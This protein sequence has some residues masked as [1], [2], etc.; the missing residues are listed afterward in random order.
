MDIET[1]PRR[2]TKVQRTTKKRRPWEGRLTAPD[3]PRPHEPIARRARWRHPKSN[4]PVA[5]TR[6]G[7][8]EAGLRQSTDHGH[9]EALDVG[10]RRTP[11][12]IST[13][14]TKRAWVARR[15]HPGIRSAIRVPSAS[16][17]ERQPIPNAGG[18]GIRQNAGI[19]PGSPREA[20]RI[21]QVGP[22]IPTV[23]IQDLEQM[24]TIDCRPPHGGL[25]SEFTRPRNG[26]PGQ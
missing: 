4:R 3:R 25:Y 26:T 10:Y 6:P 20:G 18:G 21:G 16:G 17:P 9:E 1:P 13:P 14:R 12:G 2:L 22:R 7:G 5:P 24:D 23:S 15:G 19:M 8:L 11:P